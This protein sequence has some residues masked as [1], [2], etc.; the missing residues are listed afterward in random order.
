MSKQ[1]KD[2]LDVLKPR[3]VDPSA[4]TTY[5]IA[6]HLGVSY[7]RAAYVCR[8]MVRNGDAVAVW[9]RVNG[10]FLRAFRLTIGGRP[11]RD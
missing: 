3:T 9:K 8:E 7:T 11:S 2:I 1:V 10:R 6:E 5:E 4:R